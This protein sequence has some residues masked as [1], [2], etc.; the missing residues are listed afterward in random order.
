MNAYDYYNQYNNVLDSTST[1][2]AWNSLSLVLAIVGGILIYFLFVKSDKHYANDL[3]NKLKEF[4]NF[5]K[6]ILEAILK[7]TYLVLTLYITFMSFNYISINFWYFLMMLFIGNVVLRIA[8]ESILLFIVIVKNTTEINNKLTK[9]SVKKA[10]KKEDAKKI[11]KEI[12]TE[13]E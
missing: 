4:L 13:E 2:I 8:Y 5:K 1:T 12:K 11:V 9:P 10:D 3:V 6:L 7:V